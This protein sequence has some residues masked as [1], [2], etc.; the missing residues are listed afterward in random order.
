MLRI[1]QRSF[2]AAISFGLTFTVLPSIAADVST[3]DSRASWLAGIGSVS[4]FEDF[5]GFTVP[6][7][8]V[9]APVGLNNMILSGTVGINPTS[10]TQL[11][12][13]PPLN[14]L[15][16][17]SPNGTAYLLAD[18]IPGGYTQLTFLNPVRAWSADFTGISNNRITHLMFKASGGVTVFDLAV[19]STPGSDGQFVSRFIGVSSEV[20]IYSVVMEFNG[21]AANDVFGVDNIAFAVAVPELPTSSLLLAGC[22]AITCV[23]F[24]RKEFRWR[25]VGGAAL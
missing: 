25:T 6:T 5:E 16:A 14:Y 9:S 4:G 19:P 2:G 3:Y 1:F 24:R 13:A 10:D 15:S 22:L 20:P 12:D 23:A 8:F 11:V 7:S 21:R 17:Y 18:L